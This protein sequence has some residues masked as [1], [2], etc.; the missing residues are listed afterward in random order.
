[1]IANDNYYFVYG[2]AGREESISSFSVSLS[3]FSPQLVNM[4]SLSQ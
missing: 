2:V 3:H 4:V 1:M